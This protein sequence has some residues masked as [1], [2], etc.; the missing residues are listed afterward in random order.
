MYFFT[1]NLAERRRTLL[2]DHVNVLRAVMQKVKTMHPFHIDAMVVLP[3][4]LHT[5]WTL[6]E[7]DADYPMRWALIKT[8][9]ARCLPKDEH[10]N[11]SRL[12]KGEQ[13]IWQR[14]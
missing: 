13:E 3:D 1:V 8:G 10:R 14:R 7:D 6:P 9:F 12:A 4:H 2:V 5:I 11:Q